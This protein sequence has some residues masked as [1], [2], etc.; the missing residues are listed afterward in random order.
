MN[1][2]FYLVKLVVER[3]TYCDEPKKRI[4][5]VK[6]LFFCFMYIKPESVTSMKKK[7]VGCIE[8]IDVLNR[9]IIVIL[10]DLEKYDKTKISFQKIFDYVYV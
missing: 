5:V 6:F 10:C 1:C 7:K 3:L 9:C 2:S 8:H 4:T